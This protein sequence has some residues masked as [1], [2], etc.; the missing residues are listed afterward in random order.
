MNHVNQVYNFVTSSL[1]EKYCLTILN[2]LSKRNWSLDQWFSAFSVPENHLGSFL[3]MQIT[4]LHLQRLGKGPRTCILT[5]RSLLILVHFNKVPRWFWCKWPMDLWETLPPIIRGCAYYFASIW[6]L[7][8][9]LKSLPELGSQYCASHSPGCLVFCW[10]FPG[11]LAWTWAKL[12][13]IMGSQNISISQPRPPQYL[14][15]VAYLAFLLGCL[16]D[17][18]KL[19][20]L[21]PNSWSFPLNFLCS[22]CS[23]S[24][25]MVALSF[26]LSRW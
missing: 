23:P 14:Y 13:L 16:I 22:N 24:Q 7:H 10:V 20:C 25:L 3:A 1:Y 11:C 9:V 4:E 21:K 18:T 19:F 6:C 8:K 2:Y 12:I 26:Q 17:I 5:T 15:P